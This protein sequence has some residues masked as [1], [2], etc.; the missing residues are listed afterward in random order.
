VEDFGPGIPADGM[1][2]IFE[3][4]YRAEPDGQVEGHGLGLAV[5][6]RIARLLGGDLTVESEAGRGSVFSLW[7]PEARAAGFR[8]G[9]PDRSGPA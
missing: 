6:R 8:P 5:A 7:L 9:L 4:F 3:E 2:R 1:A